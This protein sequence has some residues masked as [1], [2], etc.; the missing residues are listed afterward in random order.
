MLLLQMEDV[1]DIIPC[2][3]DVFMAVAERVCI[4]N[5]NQNIVDAYEKIFFLSTGGSCYY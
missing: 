2:S 5:E 4:V 1:I 3:I